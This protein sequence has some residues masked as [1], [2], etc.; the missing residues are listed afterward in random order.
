MGLTVQCGVKFSFAKSVWLI[1]NHKL[2]IAVVS[3]MLLSLE[4]LCIWWKIGRN[5]KRKE[6]EPSQCF[7]VPLVGYSGSNAEKETLKC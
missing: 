5:V 3:L 4:I 1:F 6:K 2:K 7:L